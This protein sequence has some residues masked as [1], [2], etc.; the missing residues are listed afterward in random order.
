MSLSSLRSWC[1]AFAAAF[2]IAV[3]AIQALRPF[4]LSAAEFSYQGD[5][6]LRVAGYAFSIWGLIYLGMVAHAGYQVWLG[7]R[8]PTSPGLVWASV[9]AMIGCG[10]WIIA[11]ALNGV[12]ATMAI[13]S[14]SALVMILALIDAPRATRPT[15]MWC[16]RAPLSLLAGWLTI[17]AIVNALTSLTIA[18]VL[19]PAQAHVG[20]LAA[21]AFAVLIAT[22]VAWRA[23]NA[24]YLAPIAWGLGGVYVAEIAVKP[25]VANAALGAAL[26]L[27][28][29]ALVVARRERGAALR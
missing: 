10:A 18:G 9:A 23:R 25:I 8:S 13:L 15:E 27:L 16:V 7:A 19:G 17:A 6:T 4:G 1:L 20:A 3:P 29:W 5:G 26:A 22:F 21:I 24:V 14:A 28:A 11:A 2:A 12:W